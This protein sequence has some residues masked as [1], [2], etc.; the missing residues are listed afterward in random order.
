LSKDEKVT[1]NTLFAMYFY[2][3]DFSPCTKEYLIRDD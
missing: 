3:R 2:G 1:I